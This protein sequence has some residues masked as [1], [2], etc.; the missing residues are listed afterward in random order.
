MQHNQMI[1][2]F[3]D[4]LLLPAAQNVVRTGR[5]KIHTVYYYT[6]DIYSE[7]CNIK[8]LDHRKVVQIL[9]HTQAAALSVGL[10]FIV[11]HS[12]GTTYRKVSKRLMALGE[13]STF[14]GCSLHI[15]QPAAANLHRKTYI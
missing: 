3:D 14:A 9:T 13:T 2:Y 12:Y 4:H 8:M 11:E 5:S 15:Q 6:T 10:P 1:T 7:L